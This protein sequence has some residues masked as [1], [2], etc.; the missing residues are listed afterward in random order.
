VLRDAAFLARTAP[1]G[2]VVEG[3]TPEETQRILRAE[4]VKWREVITRA[5][6]QLEAG[7]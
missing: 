3:S 6:I 5:G 4:S 7:P 2:A 1:F